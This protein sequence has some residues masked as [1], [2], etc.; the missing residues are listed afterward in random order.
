MSPLASVGYEALTSRNA[1]FLTADEQAR[2]RASSVFVCGVGGMGGTAVQVLARAGVGRLGLADFDAFEPSNLNRQLF[3][4]AATLGRP[5]VEA[6][7]EALLDVNPELRIGTYGADWTSRLP[8]ILGAH[9]VVI[10]G[11]DDL[12]A[13][14]ALYRAARRHDA[15]VVD[16]YTSPCPSVMVV[17]PQ[18]PRPEERLGFPT[19]G[20][21][22]EALTDEAVAEAL[23]RELAFVAAVSSGLRR[24]DAG[25]AAEILAGERARSSFAPVVIA[26][27]TLMAFEAIGVLLG[28]PSGAD[29]RGYF[30]DLWGGR[31]ERPGPEW[32]VRL[33]SLLAARALRRLSAEGER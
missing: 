7:R 15:T 31:V 28:R 33:R 20:V 8:E 2:L 4:T 18:D 6:T 17:R 16:A 9:D 32:L 11:M 24:F 13:A 19:L 3:A 26:A 10:N 12:R 29:H 23:L 21:A 25:V 14:V 1:G 5:K 30:L 27:G 22:P